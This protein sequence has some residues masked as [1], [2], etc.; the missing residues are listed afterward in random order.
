MNYRMWFPLGKS[1]NC[2]G[3]SNCS[4]I[5]E[6]LDN[7]TYLN[8]SSGIFLDCLGDCVGYLSDAHVAELIEFEA[9]SA[10]SV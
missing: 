7:Y 10:R 5:E 3:W 6:A 2:A 1:A 4:T 8:C 9:A